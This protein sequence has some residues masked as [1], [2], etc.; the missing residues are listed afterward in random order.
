MKN[1]FTEIIDLKITALYSFMLVLLNS[2]NIKL[3]YF[4]ISGLVYLGYNIHRWYI[5]HIEFK[6]RKQK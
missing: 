4:V 5:M 1:I 6:K 2:E 3:I